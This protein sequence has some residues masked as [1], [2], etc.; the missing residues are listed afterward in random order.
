VILQ[1]RADFPE[2]SEAEE[3]GRRVLALEHDSYWRVLKG[4]ADGEIVPTDSRDPSQAVR[5]SEPWKNR[6]RDLPGTVTP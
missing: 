3:V 2:G 1:R 4:F 6:M 5:V